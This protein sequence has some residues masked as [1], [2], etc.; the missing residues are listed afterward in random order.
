MSHPG[1]GRHGLVGIGER[2]DTTP[3]TPA[4]AI[5][6]VARAHGEKAG[7]LLARF[8]GLPDGSTGSCSSAAP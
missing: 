5:R 2:L 7:R 8:I 3:P 1:A 6:G 4:E